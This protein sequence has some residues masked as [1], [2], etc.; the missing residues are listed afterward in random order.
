LYDLVSHRNWI[1]HRHSID[2]ENACGRAGASDYEGLEK[3]AAGRCHCV[4]ESQLHALQVERIADDV[5]VGIQAVSVGERW[6]AYG[7]LIE[8]LRAADVLYTGVTLQSRQVRGLRALPGCPIERDY[9][10]G[11]FS[12]PSGAGIGEDDLA[13]AWTERQ[14]RSRNGRDAKPSYTHRE[15]LAAGWREATETAAVGVHHKDAFLL[16]LQK[17][18]ENREVICHLEHYG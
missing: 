13:T 7:V 15:R 14:G 8:K 17:L 1:V 12:V 18:P 3:L 2:T 4:S 10:P 9:F 5:L 16:G 6:E 11:L